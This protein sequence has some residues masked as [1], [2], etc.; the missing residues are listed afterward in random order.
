MQ[1]IADANMP[2]LEPFDA[3]G[4]VTRVDGRSLTRQQLGEAEVLLVR[5]VT[6]VDA[7]LLAGSRV[8]FVGSATIGT[9]HVDLAYLQRQG[10]RFAHA[11]GCNARAVAEYVLQA[12]LLLCEA[13]NRSPRGATAA[14]V[15]LGNVGLQVADWLT[16]LGMKVRACDPPLAGQGYAGPYRL[17]PLDA[18]LDADLITLHV[19]LTDSGDHATRHLLD[20]ARLSRLSASQMLI[21]TCRGP[22]IDNE[23]LLAR[24]EVGQAP[25]TILDVWEAEP[26]V[27]PALFEQVLL[28]SPHIA[29]YSAEGKL[30]GTQML[31]QAFCDWLGVTAQP[32]PVSARNEIID[33][34]VANEEDLLRVLQVAYRLSEDHQRL[35]DSLLS[36]EPGTAFDRLRKEYPVR[37]ELHDWCYQGE[38][39]APWQR[40]MHRLF[41]RA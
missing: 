3:M 21:N 9:D 36:E 32:A 10:I 35:G 26:Q 15:G 29:G 13:G 2:G 11:P 16:D 33:Q 5:S 18:M 38:V 34:Q 22:V 20:A 17:E 28:G 24:L 6:R 30:K 31:Y 4:T 37:H 39:A 14:V 41:A 23:A 12:V 7:D 27:P 19:P 1:I 25:A 40:I 8:R